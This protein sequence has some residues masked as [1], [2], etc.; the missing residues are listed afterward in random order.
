[1]TARQRML[2]AYRNQQP[3]SVPVSPELWDATAIAVSGRP[4]YELMGPLA[5]VPWWQTHLAAFVYFGADAWIVPAPGETQRQKEIRSVRSHFLDDETV[6]SD[7][8]WRTPRGN[9][10]AVARTTSTY[11]DWLFRHPVVDFPA[12]MEIYADYFF[13][14]PEDYD[15]SEI[16]Q[17][18]AGVGEKGLVT[19]MVGELFSSFLG[20]VREGGMAQTIYDL[21]DHPKYCRRLQAR[22]IEHISRTTR[23]ILEQTKAQ[24]IF[25]NSNYSG[26]PIVSPALYRE[27]DKPVLAAV[28]QVCRQYNVPLHLHQHGRVLPILDDLIEAGVSIVCPLL[29]PPQGDVADLAEVKRR[30][31]SRIAL[32]GF[33]DPIEVLLKKTPREVQQAV[34]QAIAAAGPGGGYILSTADSTVIRTPFENIHAFVE[35]GRKYGRYPLSADYGTVSS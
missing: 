22:F 17:A 24:A 26:P 31:G 1:M 32:K 14:D 21:Y 20:G 29:P 7:I 12:D 2:T 16:N 9:L 35:A 4:F 27:W 3:D 30:Y 11:A 23:A 19:P 15:L 5:E 34:R 8:T 10:H 18:I 13:T 28:A 6:Q 25:V 33:V